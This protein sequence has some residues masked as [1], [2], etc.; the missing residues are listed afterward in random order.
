M[1]PVQIN[2]QTH[3]GGGEVYTAFLCR[4]LSALGVETTLFVHPR[5]HFWSAIALP[6]DTR[7][8]ITDRFLPWPMP[9]PQA[10]AGCS[11]M[12]P[13]CRTAGRRQRP[14]AG[15]GPQPACVRWPRSNLRSVRLGARWFTCSANS[16][17]AENP[18]LRHQ[19]AELARQ[20]VVQDYS[21]E[22]MIKKLEGIYVEVHELQCRAA[23]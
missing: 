15:A 20:R 19:L 8:E 23:I 10:Q 4:T 14:H 1:R 17:L 11:V 3:F 2:P 16:R 21:V 22:P 9:C 5:A 18:A 6:A 7:I 13:A 12:P